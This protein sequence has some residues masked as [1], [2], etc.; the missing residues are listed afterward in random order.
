MR[1]ATREFG[2]CRFGDWLKFTALALCMLLLSNY[3]DFSPPNR[4][5]TYDIALDTAIGDWN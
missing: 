1:G 3:V 2:C 4:R 5:N